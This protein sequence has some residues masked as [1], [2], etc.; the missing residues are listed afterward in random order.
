MRRVLAQPATATPTLRLLGYFY[1]PSTANSFI[2]RF[3]YLW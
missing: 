3:T 1:R 2:G